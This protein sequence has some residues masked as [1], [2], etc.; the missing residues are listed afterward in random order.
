M[1]EREESSNESQQR[2][3]TSVVNVERNDNLDEV[4]HAAFEQELNDNSKDPRRNKMWFVAGFIV[5][6]TSTL[7]LLTLVWGYK[8]AS[9]LDYYYMN[10]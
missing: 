8:D 5:T 1:S 2:S 4:V 3:T 9:S 7:A 6:A 10:G